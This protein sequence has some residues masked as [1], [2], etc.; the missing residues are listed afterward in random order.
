MIFN[1]LGSRSQVPG[2]LEWIIVE[3][4][5]TDIFL[6]ARDQTPPHLSILE[7]DSSPIR[8]AWSDCTKIQ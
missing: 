8:L 4:K 2:F 7:P 3:F 1:V 5:S 6:T